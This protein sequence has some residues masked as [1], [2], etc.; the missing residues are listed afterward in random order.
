[1]LNLMLSIENLK[2]YH[3]KIIIKKHVKILM[4]SSFFKSLHE[5]ARNPNAR[6][7]NAFSQELSHSVEAFDQHNTGTCWLQSGLTYLSIMAK[8]K[9]IDFTPSATYL[10]L[11]DK[12]EK[13]AV[14]LSRM[15]KYSDKETIRFLLNEPI[16]DGG[17]WP[18]FV[19]LVTKYGIVSNESY[20]LTFQGKN[21]KSLNKILKSYLRRAS[22][23]ITMEKIPMH[24]EK[25]FEILMI[26]FSLPPDHFS[27]MQNNEI[28]FNGTP[29]QFVQKLD[30]GLERYISLVDAP[31]RRRITYINFATND[32]TNEEQHV[33][34]VC[35]LQTI[36]KAC[37]LAIMSDMPVWFTADVHE[38][39]DFERNIM[40]IDC[41]DVDNIFD[42]NIKLSKAQKMK[43]RSL[44]PCHAMLMVGVH[45]D[46]V[47][48][49]VRWKVQNS[50][51]QKKAFLA[52]SDE[53]FTEHVFE[54]VV[55]Y[56]SALLTRDHDK[57][58][59]LRP[60]DILSTV[61]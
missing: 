44:L 33:F 57:I 19:F 24:L 14:F 32:Y 58:Q 16:Q 1:M 49:P 12:L 20:P 60:W 2:R 23:N 29:L 11:F 8:K 41:V 6:V 47:G 9:N 15:C 52:M 50:Y 42:T 40:E 54:I 28:V 59:Y 25:V 26:S 37:K 48:N 31:D 10:M 5:V 17:T 34:H 39:V 55:P 38:D 13:A 22:I 43:C 36:K 46:E 3:A 56:E 18:M 61:A 21:T 30:M 45:C 27:I 51:G 7:L 35:E 53:W 4:A